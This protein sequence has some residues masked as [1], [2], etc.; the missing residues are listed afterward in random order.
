LE[1]SYSSFRELRTFHGGIDTAQSLPRCPCKVARLAFSSSSSV[2]P[3]QS[4]YEPIKLVT[5][6]ASAGDEAPEDGKYFVSTLI[7]AM[8]TVDG[9]DYSGK[10]GEQNGD[11][12]PSV[13]SRRERVKSR[14]GC[15][16][17][18]RLT[19]PIFHLS[20][21][22]FEGIMTDIEIESSPSP[23]MAKAVLCHH[24]D[25]VVHRISRR[26]HSYGR[27]VHSHAERLPEPTR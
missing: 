16:A 27:S 1:P 26:Q 8:E 9:C 15:A 7:P 17:E 22:S 14:L 23:T 18:L 6:S 24:G 21:P 11:S 19:S 12:G 2:T 25:P 13:L 10:G 4:I 20:S 5:C 3:I